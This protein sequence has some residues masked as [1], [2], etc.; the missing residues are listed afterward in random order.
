MSQQAITSIIGRLQWPAGPVCRLRLERGL[1]SAIERVDAPPADVPW[2]TPGFVDAH[3]HPPLLGDQLATV[4]LSE[5]ASYA[6]ALRRIESAARGSG[7]L[8][9]SGWDQNRWPDVPQ[10]AWPLASDLERVSRGRP[11][12][13][14]RVDRHAVWVSQAALAAAGIGR[15]T[16]D[17][18]GG[19]IVRDPTGMPSGVLVDRAAELVTPAVPDMPER[20][21]RLRAALASLA[22]EGLV[23]VHDMA[24][25]DATWEL[26]RRLD[27]A[28]ELPIRVWAWMLE[29]TSAA[30]DLFREGPHRGRRLAG[31]GI[32]AFAD[33]ALGSHGALLAEPYCDDACTR[34]L[35]LSD[36]AALREL[37]GSCAK[38]GLQLAVHAIGDAA[39]E[40]ALSSFEAAS[41]SHGPASAPMRIEHAQILGPD[42]ARRMA[43][44]GVVASVQPVH[45]TSDMGWAER[46]L[47]PDRIRRAYAWRTLADAGVRIALGSD[48]PIERAD[49]SRGLWAAVTRRSWNGDPPEGWHAEQ[50]LTLQ[51]AVAGFTSGAAFAAGDDPSSVALQ[52]GSRADLTLWKASGD[53]TAPRVAAIG[54]VIDGRADAGKPWER[55]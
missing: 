4:D 14:H 17:P 26:Y 20:E 7:W 51:E 31:R 3:G 46:L 43:R 39:I 19:H 15:D 27:D 16:P 53:A 32:K 23:G 52:P 18:P 42:H 37:A 12:L 30:R 21:R 8:V 28:G 49:P 40:A 25:D 9:G 55:D 35:P 33:G 1:I 54:S 50:R 22:A 5:A 48:F 13:L 2:L 10:G 38:S 34:G 6:D 44:I 24:V 41:Q 11:A 45:A 47:G 29:D 36:A